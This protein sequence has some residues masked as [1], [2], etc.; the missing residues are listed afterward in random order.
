MLIFRIRILIV[1]RRIFL[2]NRF[3]NISLENSAS[4]TSLDTFVTYIRRIDNGEQACGPFACY[5][6]ELG[7]ETHEAGFC[8]SIGGNPR[9]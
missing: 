9:K 6:F 3:I 7:Q 4:T 2:A 1:V 8:N 5:R